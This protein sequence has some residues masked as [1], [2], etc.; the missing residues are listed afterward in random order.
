VLREMSALKGFTIRATNGKVGRVGYCLFDD[1]V[2]VVRFLVVETG[3]WP[4]GVRVLLA[5]S[6][7]EGV[8][9]QAGTISSSHTTEEIRGGPPIDEHAPV[10]RQHELDFL[11]RYALPLPT[12]AGLPGMGYFV[13][14]AARNGRAVSEV[15][16]S[17]TARTGDPHL[18]STRKIEGYSLRAV[19]GSIGHVDGFVIDDANWVVRYL[20]VRTRNWLPGKRVL[21]APF[22]IAD[23]SWSR[24]SVLVGLTRSAIRT[25]PSYEATAPI[26]REY[27]ARLHSHFDRPV[28]W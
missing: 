9:W 21:L 2:W 28:Y 20:V 8:D 24:R 1:E 11:D 16:S 25:A 10:C 19:D 27:E 6:A 15:A 4:T 17:R 23:I 22:W 26:T 5:P 14:P 7:V 3:S 13:A 18:R 12:E